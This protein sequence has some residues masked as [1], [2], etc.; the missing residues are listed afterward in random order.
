[1]ISIK[2]RIE[3]TSRHTKVARHVKICAF[4]LKMDSDAEFPTE[5]DKF[6]SDVIRTLLVVDISVFISKELKGSKI[7][8]N[9]FGSNI[10]RV[11]LHD[12]NFY[13][14]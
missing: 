7:P 10:S 14:R 11:E 1:M 3:T 8:C 12:T 9:S 2:T 13:G 6:H 4:G 5:M